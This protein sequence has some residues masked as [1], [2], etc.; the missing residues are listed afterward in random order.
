MTKQNTSKWILQATGFLLGLASILGGIA[1][2]YYGFS[3]EPERYWVAAIVMVVGGIL[4]IVHSTSSKYQLSKKHIIVILTALLLGLTLG[5]FYTFSSCGGECGGSF[6]RWE[7]GY[8]GRWFVIGGCYV[9]TDTSLNFQ[10]NISHWHVDGISFLA[11]IIFWSA[12]GLIIAFFWQ[13]ISSRA[14]KHLLP[15]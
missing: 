3:K 15:D 5:L 7:R 9:A 12:A 4:W 14:D 6:C 13:I 1:A 11:D 8:P 2:L 10:L